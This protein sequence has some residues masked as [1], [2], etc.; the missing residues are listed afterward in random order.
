MAGG[1][2][3]APKTGA[4]PDG[5]VHSRDM[6][7]YARLRK[8]AEMWAPATQA[9][10]DA[11]G[12]GPGMRCLD[13]G[14]GTGAA[15]QLMGRM[16]GPGGRVVGLEIDETLA[17]ASLGALGAHEGRCYAMV[18][19]DIAAIEAL[20]EGPF[21]VTFCRMFLMHMADPVAVLQKMG[22]WTIPGGLI[23]AQEF[24]FI[25][26]AIEPPCPPMAEFMRVFEG[27]FLSHGRNMRAGRQLPAQFEAA[28]L[29]AP[30]GTDAAVKFVPL[31]EMS[32]M[33]IGVYRSLYDSAA[34]LG[35]ADE[36][37][38]RR[39]EAEMRDAAEDGRYYCLTPTLIA[40][41]S[42]LD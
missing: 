8:Q 9:V 34:R 15:M 31:S 42:R 11:A 2:A 28:G 27:V 6:A 29:G 21:D 36:A 4:N 35:L 12:V 18:T 5:Y 7:E 17:E 38:A 14:A 10:L 3:S 33:L 37:G 1:Q 32:E 30:A 13:V 40:A 26:I 39:F 19:G 22:D 25:S 41:W 24:D 20:P 16:V 23:I